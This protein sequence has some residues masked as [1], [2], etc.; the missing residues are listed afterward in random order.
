MVLYLIFLIL[1]DLLPDIY[2]RVLNMSNFKKHIYLPESR[3]IELL[4]ESNRKK[5]VEGPITP[6]L[7]QIKSH[8]NSEATHTLAS[9][10]THYHN[11]G[12]RGREEKLMLPE[13]LSWSC[14]MGVGTTLRGIHP[15]EARTT[16]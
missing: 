13:T 7:E 10:G 5:F 3:K 1:L 11:Q 2:F 14:L 15:L 16:K 9:L 12:W 8:M 4:P 6:M